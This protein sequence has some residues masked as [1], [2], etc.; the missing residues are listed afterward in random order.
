MAAV[1]CEQGDQVER[2]PNGVTQ[3]DPPANGKVACLAVQP[4]DTVILPFELSADDATLHLEEADGTL[5]IKDHGATVLLQ[6]YFEAS[7][8]PQHPVVI[9]DV[10]RVPT[11]VAAW[12]ANS[13]PD[14]DILQ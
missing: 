13:A 2:S 10:H 1:A 3:I 14:L 12:F 4:G 7:S 5:V 6:G 11:D 9:Q 8:D